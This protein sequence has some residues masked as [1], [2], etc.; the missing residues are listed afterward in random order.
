[1]PFVGFWTGM[2]F[3][4]LCTR[5]FF[6]PSSGSGTLQFTGLPDFGGKRL[7]EIGV[8]EDLTVERGLNVRGA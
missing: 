6:G 5:G 4:P 7:D 2:S 1:M 8:V 3:F